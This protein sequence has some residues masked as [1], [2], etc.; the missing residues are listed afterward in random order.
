MS[1]DDWTRLED[2]MSELH[3][4]LIEHADPPAFWGPP[5]EAAPPNAEE[6]E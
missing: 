6:G 2:A 4:R 1:D 3:D 5:N